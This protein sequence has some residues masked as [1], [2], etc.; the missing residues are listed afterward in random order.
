MNRTTTAG[1]PSLPWISLIA[2]ILLTASCAR[3]EL[4][5]SLRLHYPGST[6]TVEMAPESNT[7]LY[8]AAGLVQDSLD[9]LLDNFDSTNPN[10]QI[11]RINRLAW[12]V[13]LPIDPYTYQIL[14]HGR[15]VHAL[16]DGAFDYTTAP[17][18]YAWGF[19]GGDT[20]S[21]FPDALIDTIRF[22]FGM[23]KVKLREFSISLRYESNAIDLENL[24]DGYLADICLRRV[25]D[26]VLGNFIIKADAVTRCWGSR[27]TTEPWMADIPDPLNLSNQ[28]ARV[29]L[30]TGQAMAVTHA[31]SDYR[32]VEGVK[33]SHIIDPIV[34]KP[35]TN[36]LM[37]VVLAPT[38]TE[39]QAFSAAA[40][41]RGVT[42]AMS[43]REKAA[44]IELMVV[45][46]GEPLT[47]YV[48]PGFLSQL[49]PGSAIQGA[50]RDLPPAPKPK[51]KTSQGAGAPAATNA[52]PAEILIP[53]EPGLPAPE[54]K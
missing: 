24:L 38:A 8:Q 15:R 2:G 10:S 1:I 26:N 25:R 50:I 3:E 42:G 14:Y 46:V 4:P 7:H 37:T 12:T 31:F 36:T 32:V 5:D 44:R 29:R 53:L 45:P 6:L 22:S 52:V 54:K 13:E 51:E 40:L 18:S 47:Y 41:V 48:S 30:K 19:K 17:I 33:R 16:S 20:P 28:V 39:A 43:M 49:D 11:S 23:D 35:V 21:D 34:G 9:N 27:S